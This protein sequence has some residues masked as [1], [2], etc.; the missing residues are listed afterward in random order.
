MSGGTAVL[1]F[2]NNEIDTTDPTPDAALNDLIDL[3]DMTL[4]NLTLT[5]YFGIDM[6]T[7]DLVPSDSSLEIT[8]NAASGGVGSGQ[9]VMSADITHGRFLAVGTNFVAY[10]D[11]QDDLGNI[12]SLCPGYSDVIDAFAA[13]DAAGKYV[14][15]S[16]SGDASQIITKLLNGT[17]D[18]SISGTLSGQLT[19][20]IPEP[21]TAAL[22]LCLLL[23][24]ICLLRRD[25]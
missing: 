13:A 4:T 14:D 21:S 12:I 16:I 1:S 18:G 7:A 6:I 5:N 11:E 24:G 19:A 23:S 10:S 3:P 20:A 2:T 25:R 9:V 15:L 22:C 17:S 8:A